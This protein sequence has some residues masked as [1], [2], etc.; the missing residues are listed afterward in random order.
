MQQSSV[1]I[2]VLLALAAYAMWGFAPVYF[3][4]LY[5]V[6][7]AEILM[8]RVIWSVAVLLIL[9][10]L[11]KQ[12]RQVTK[13]VCD[14]KVMRVLLVTGLLLAANWFLFIWA[15]NN[16]RLLDASL[17][18]YINPLLNVFLGRMFLGERLRR[19]QQ[20]AVATAALGVTIMVVSYG[21][22]P[23]ISLML[24]GTFGVYG[25]LRK[26]VPVGSLPGLLIESLFMLP[27]ALGYWYLFASDASNLFS[28]EASLNIVLI[29]AGIVTTAPLICF[30]SAAKRIQYSTLGFFQYLGPSIMFALAVLIYNEPLDYEKLLTFAFVWS[31]LV[32]F[33]WDSWR[34]YRKSKS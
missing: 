23:W 7:A 21:Q 12:L 20:V 26:K 6:P 32:I 29:S 17:G 9:V 22:I 2:G 10:L 33:S 13:A 16:D 15:V 8:H 11:T 3:K 30:V 14:A 24:A 18:Y 27:L 5:Q 4:L 31:A 34:S 28:N 19:F 1:K 25:L